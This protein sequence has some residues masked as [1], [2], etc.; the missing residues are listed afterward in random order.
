MRGEKDR[1]AGLRAQVGE[2]VPDG[3]ARHRIEA[4][5]RLVEEEQAWLVEQGLRDL[6]TADHAARVGARQ[7]VARVGKPHVRQRLA[8]TCLAIAVREVIE[9]RKDQPSSPS[10]CVQPRR[11]SGSGGA[12]F[13]APA[14][15][16]SSPPGC[17]QVGTYVRPCATAPLRH[18]VAVAGLVG[19][20]EH[21]GG[22]RAVRAVEQEV[23]RRRLIW[24][25][26][27]HAPP[28]IRWRFLTISPFDCYRARRWRWRHDLH[29]NKVS[30]AGIQYLLLAIGQIVKAIH[31]HPVVDARRLAPLHHD[32]RNAVVDQL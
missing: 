20:R 28:Q 23:L 14:V 18:Q 8:D 4:R 3:A 25:D 17:G 5:R 26:L 22:R 7:P 9:P 32:S 13:T 31:H 11:R 30:G 24:P 27:A 12:R 10:I 16:N 1:H 15:H 29:L 6:Q 2:A 21:V 19:V